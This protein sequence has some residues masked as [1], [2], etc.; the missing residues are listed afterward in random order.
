MPHSFVG[1]VSSYTMT[2]L[3]RRDAAATATRGDVDEDDT[4]TATSKENS[5]LMQS[6]EL[7]MRGFL[8]DELEHILER[9][10][11][12]PLPVDH[13][14]EEGVA[15]DSSTRTGSDSYSTHHQLG[16]GDEIKC[17]KSGSH[18]RLFHSCPFY[19]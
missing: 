11:A 12:A 19:S 17:S 10:V 6:L 3:N 18:S 15:I 16:C 9:K 7:K 14:Y 8:K 13:D 4:D 2:T 5:L 1:S